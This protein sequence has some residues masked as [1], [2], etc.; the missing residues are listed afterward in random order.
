[1]ITRMSCSKTERL[2]I[3]ST[4][5]GLRPVRDIR[6]F[7]ICPK[8]GSDETNVIT[9]SERAVKYKGRTRLESKTVTRQDKRLTVC[10]TCHYTEGSL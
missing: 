9:I 10:R 8:C 4:T 6:H 7:V 3:N 2:V 5:R 1:M